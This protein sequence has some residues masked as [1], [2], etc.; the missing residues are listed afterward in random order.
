MK[1]ADAAADERSTP[2]RHLLVSDVDDTLLGDEEA[3]AEF[4]SW[5]ESARAWLDLAYA[6]GRFVD[7]VVASIHEEGLPA[8]IAVI[9][10][11]GTQIQWYPSGDRI[12]EW[13]VTAGERWSADRV[14]EV[15]ANVDGLR[16]QPSASQSAYKISYYFENASPGE[17]KAIRDLLDGAG[18]STDL[19]YSSRRDLDVVPR[20]VNKGSAARYLTEQ[21]DVPDDHVLVSGNSAN[22]R[23]LFLPGFRGIVVGN[24]DD[25]LK[26]VAAEGAYLARQGHARGVLEGIRAWTES[27]E[28]S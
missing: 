24:A 14:R 21:L 28:R 20:G 17:L 27:G 11:V 2:V 23:E 26:S 1:P 4:R 9:G 7:S 5:Y 10:G 6:S 13:P 18:L 16:P 19:V 22:D 25:E 15:L 3:L 12:E 8:P